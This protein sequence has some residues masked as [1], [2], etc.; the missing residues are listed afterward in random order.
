MNVIVVY[1]SRYGS[2]K[3]IAE[4]IAEKLR[5]H[6][7]QAEARSVEA[8]PNPGEYDAVVI[9]SA[10]YMEHWMKGAVEFVRQ[11][12]AVLAGRPVWLFSSGPLKLEPG[13]SPGDPGLEPREIG[14]FREVIHPRDHRVFFG[15]LDPR[16]LGFAHRAL[17][18]LPAGR[19]LLPEGDFRNWDYIE[20]WSGD[21]VRALKTP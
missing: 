3:G 13:T 15:A 5:A 20:A 17:R 8:G 12:R 9:G 2:T 18:K 6:G 4:F 1:A 7:V 21:I 14:E 11:N 16:R 10:V 19:A